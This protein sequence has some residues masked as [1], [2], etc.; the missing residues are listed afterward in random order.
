MGVERLETV[1][2]LLERE[3]TVDGIPV[4]LARV[5]LPK[6]KAP[7]MDRHLRRMDRYYRQ[8]ARSYLRYCGRF[9]L[10]RAQ[11]EFRQAAAAGAPLPHFTAAMDYR[12]TWNEGGVW[13]LYTDARERGGLP[14]TIRRGDTWDLRTGTPIPLSAFLPARTPVRRL[15]PD[16]AAQEIRRQQSAGVAA[17]REDWQRRLRR[18]LCTG[19]YYLTTEGICFFYQMYALAPAA[20][21]TPVFCLPWGTHGTA[22][23]RTPE[24]E[25]AG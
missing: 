4:L 16:L 1:E 14:L 19:N 23:P 2:E 12:V 24:P 15:L 13:S 20:E 18:E 3:W 17:Y 6:L 9:L 22:A 7:E 25:E 8:F 5:S 11:A 10:P 21:G